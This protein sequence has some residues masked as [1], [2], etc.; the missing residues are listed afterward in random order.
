MKTRVEQLAAGE[1]QARMY[2]ALRRSEDLRLPEAARLAKLRFAETAWGELLR[3]QRRERRALH[4]EQG[5]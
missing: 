4:L 5:I 2:A 3:R 1:L